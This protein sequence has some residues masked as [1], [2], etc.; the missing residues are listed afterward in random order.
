V[1]DREFLATV[2]PWDS[3]G[4]VTIHWR[5]TDGQHHGFSGRSCQSLDDV[6]AVLA[7]LKDVRADVYFCISTQRTNSGKR[8]RVNAMNLRVVPVDL[9]VDPDNPKKYASLAEA[10]AALFHFCQLLDIPNPSFLVASGGGLHAYWLSDR[11]LTVDQWQPFADV[12]KTAALQSSLKLDPACTGNAVQLLRVPGTAN[13]KL[14]TPRPVRLLPKYCNGIAHDFAVIF[15]RVIEDFPSVARQHAPTEPIQIAEA[16]KH[17]D[18]AKQLGE[19]I[20]V[21]EAPLLPLAPIKAECG[22][23]RTAH[24]SGGRDYDN[25]QW[26]LTTLCATFLVDGHK[27]AHEFGQ[28]HPTYLPH[29]TDEIYA[30]KLRER[31]HNPR[32]G[33]P[34]CQTIRNSGG[35]VHCDA[36]VHLKR[37]KSPLSIGWE[38]IKDDEADEELRQ[39]GGSRPP[40]MRLPPD[41]ALDDQQRISFL[42]RSVTVKN[43]VIPG[44]L[45]HL[46]GNQLRDPSLQ[47]Q[48]GVYGIAFTASM[49]RGGEIGIFIPGP[50]LIKANIYRAL[51]ERS[52]T[53]N[54][55]GEATKLLE[56]FGMSWLDKLMHEDVALRDTGTMGWRYDNGERTGFAYGSKLYHVSGEETQVVGTDDEFRSW[57]KPT[58]TREAW[59]KAAKLLTDRKR[60]ELDCII[61]VAFAAPLTVFAGAL[62]G[63]ILSVWGPPGT[64]KSTAQQVAAAVWGHP[65]QT[66]ESLTS[67]AKSVQG[68]LGRTRNLPAYWDDVQDER[69]QDSLFQTMFVAAEG[70]EGGRLNRDASYKQRLEWQTLLVACSNA[71]FVDYLVKKQ[72]STTAGIR[73]V[74]EYPYCRRNEP[75]MVDQLEASRTFA[76]LEHNFGVIGADYAKLLARDH[77]NI[78]KL[79]TDTTV[80]FTK[81]VNGTNEEAFWWGLCGVLLAGATLAQKFGV[82]FDVPAMAAFLQQAYRDNRTLRTAEGTES[83]SYVHTELALTGFLNHYAG[84]GHILFVDRMFEHK[85]VEVEPLTDPMK[86]KPLYIQVAR[87]TRT[88]LI[89]KRAL[90][91]Y[92]E[93]NDIHP[94]PVFEGLVKYFNTKEAKL[95]IGAG[96]VFAMTQENCIELQVQPNHPLFEQLVTAWG[97]AQF[98]KPITKPVPPTSSA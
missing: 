10:I 21:R 66:R 54:T 69:H 41:F 32:I 22:W 14:A 89:S 25:P 76:A 2:V 84:A 77:H 7:N 55:D 91:T 53:Y 20:V 59:L 79:V 57:Y 1:D 38:A 26:N 51:M 44:R 34:H 42:F 49:D 19:G 30:R 33:W 31:K 45:L 11:V 8:S 5:R 62:Y 27:L 73:R 35:A 70:A 36:C 18:P 82:E 40:A 81:Q 83:G 39:L 92:L 56:K 29:K 96:T 74:F 13:Q 17:L 47:F 9:D 43:K 85:N 61:A 6:F 67:T 3:G 28:A 87:A 97:N 88:I 16:F 12:L 94:R 63:A 90:R 37:A 52:I 86:G 93:D 60:P 68:R 4:Y 72:K 15:K 95:T 48:N 65:K 50:N 98:T 71:S 75:G 23:L 58:G 24:D 64:S 78:E 46:I 80:T